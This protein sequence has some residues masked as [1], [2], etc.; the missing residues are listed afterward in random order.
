MSR[1]SVAVLLLLLAGCDKLASDGRSQRAGDVTVRELANDSIE[2]EAPVGVGAPLAWQVAGSAAAYGASGVTPILTIRCERSDGM[3][4]IERPGG[5]TAITIAA[6]GY[7]QTL[8]TRAAQGDKVQARVPMGDELVARMSAPQ[9]QLMLVN[10][11]GEQVAIPGGVAVRRVLDTCRG[12]AVVAP[13]ATPDN[14]TAPVEGELP[15]PPPAE[16]AN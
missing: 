13:A 15:V 8:G 1:N 2:S 14:G 4:V 5:G 12:P 7:E 6:N 3:I 11:A 9:A 10:A 16:P